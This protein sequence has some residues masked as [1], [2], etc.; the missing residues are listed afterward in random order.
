MA[1]AFRTRDLTARRDVYPLRGTHYPWGCLHLVLRA[2]GR[3]SPLF[4]RAKTDLCRP[5]DLRSKRWTWSLAQAALQRQT[6][7]VWHKSMPRLASPG[8][9]RANRAEAVLKRWTRRL[10]LSRSRSCRRVRRACTQQVTRGGRSGTASVNV[11]A[12]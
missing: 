3:P 1:N 6:K 4:E 12:R 10:P 5:S 2:R 8:R 7:S 11:L 9:F